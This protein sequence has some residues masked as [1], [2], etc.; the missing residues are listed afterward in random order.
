MGPRP[1]PRPLQVTGVAGVQ[2]LKGEGVLVRGQV[3]GP[4]RP[5]RSLL[6]PAGPSPSAGPAPPLLSH[7]ASDASLSLPCSLTSLWE[8]GPQ[9]GMQ[10]PR[11]EG[12]RPAWGAGGVPRALVLCEGP[13][14]WERASACER[15]HLCCRRRCLPSQC[16]VPSALSAPCCPW[17]TPAH[18]CPRPSRFVDFHE[19]FL[20]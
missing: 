11:Y 9:R 2:S 13:H 1:W 16:V 18:Q 7:L 19:C 4:S 10:W 20:L 3:S 6:L 12:G 14:S 5:W 8:R 15:H 17:L